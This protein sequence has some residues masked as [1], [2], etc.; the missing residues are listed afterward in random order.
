MTLTTNIQQEINNKFLSIGGYQLVQEYL[1]E[2]D[3]IDSILFGGQTIFLS[4]FSIVEG[5]PTIVENL[6]D[7]GYQPGSLLAILNP[8]FEL[9]AQKV[10][11]PTT[12]QGEAIYQYGLTED[13]SLLLFRK[14]LGRFFFSFE[15]TQGVK[16]IEVFGLTEIPPSEQDTLLSLWRAQAESLVK[17]QINIDELFI[18]PVTQSQV[19]LFISEFQTPTLLSPMNEQVYL[20]GDSIYISS[21]TSMVLAFKEVLLT[22]DDQYLELTESDLT[23][24]LL[25]EDYTLIHQD[26]VDNSR[27]WLSSDG[28]IRLDVQFNAGLVSKVNKLEFTAL[29]LS[30]P[31]GTGLSRLKYRNGVYTLKAASKF[32]PLQPSR[33]IKLSITAGLSQ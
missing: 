32:D 33:T 30:N 1:S 23:T 12:I 8:K 9:L 22:L 29:Q 24:A 18:K 5:Q 19:S 4:S 13:E 6:T 15:T 20:K 3:L 11:E 28:N 10:L 27:Y 7:Y 31:E 26:L 17:E 21:S 14:H 16:V 2:P 25:E